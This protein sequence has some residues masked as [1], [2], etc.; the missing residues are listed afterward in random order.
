MKA[1][2]STDYDMHN[3]KCYE[4]PCC[5]KCEE[6][7]GGV[8]LIQDGDKF[9]CINCGEFFEVDDE[10]KE[11]IEERSG[12]KVEIQKCWSCGNETME[13]HYYKDNI[14]PTKWRVAG[15]KC[16]CGMSFIV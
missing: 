1:I 4:R 7:Y 11:W 13:V 8:P 12:K 15:G 16:K 9:R 14:D 10:M 3:D 5:P 2:W 6:E